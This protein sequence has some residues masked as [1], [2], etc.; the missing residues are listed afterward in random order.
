VENHFLEGIIKD[1]NKKVQKEQL[2]EANPPKLVGEQL[3]CHKPSYEK[4]Q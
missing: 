4:P 3:I 1:I 2:Q